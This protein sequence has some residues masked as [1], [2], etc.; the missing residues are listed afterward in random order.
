MERGGGGMDNHQQIVVAFMAMKR[1]G[2]DTFENTKKW[3]HKAGG[4]LP[5]YGKGLD[6]C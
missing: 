5:T 3:I 6:V 1:I 2:N 4:P